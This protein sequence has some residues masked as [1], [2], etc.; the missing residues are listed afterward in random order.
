MRAGTFYATPAGMPHFV[1]FEE[2]AI[3]QINTIG[4]WGIKYVN[5]KD[6]PRQK[7]Q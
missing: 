5:A 7:T 6:D 2:E 1:H 4:P 3:L